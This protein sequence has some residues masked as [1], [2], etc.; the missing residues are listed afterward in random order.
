MTTFTAAWVAGLYI[1][2][3][4]HRRLC[5]HP[6]FPRGE[7]SRTLSA[8]DVQNVLLGG[9]GRVQ[10][11]WDRGH[12]FLGSA[13]TGSSVHVDQV[14]WSNVGKNY[15]GHKVLAIWPLGAETH[16]ILDRWYRFLLPRPDPLTGEL[17]ED[18]A[19]DLATAS[20]V[21][22]VGPGDVF[23]FSG[24]NAH[25]T[26]VVPMRTG[27]AGMRSE[28]P[29]VRARSA[30]G[31]A[32]SGAAGCLNLTFY[33]SFVKVNLD[34]LKAL[35]NTGT[36]LHH[37]TCTLRPDDLADLKCDLAD[38]FYKALRWVGGLVGV[39]RDPSGNAPAATFPATCAGQALACRMRETVLAAAAL[40]RTDAEREV[41]RDDL[42]AGTD[43]SK[44]RRLGQHPPPVQ[45]AE[46]VIER[47][48]GPDGRA[49]Y[50]GSEA[51]E[52]GQ[53][54]YGLLPCN[55]GIDAGDASSSDPW[56]H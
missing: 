5:P 15:T 36:A 52:G 46:H 51:W 54:G 41:S 27:E 56:T 48:A 1:A 44:R 8:R 19:A 9:V 28:R 55:S 26:L 53:A 43:G 3:L 31:A 6:C 50:A 40:L 11:S 47:D 12:A 42:S 16:R 24:A 25:T 14:C 22:L 30:G 45:L 37:E 17:S 32:G 4:S 21:A 29:G 13:G 33:E 38:R 7:H 18:A 35:L 2:E 34:N 39:L 10:P 20:R 23:V 49:G